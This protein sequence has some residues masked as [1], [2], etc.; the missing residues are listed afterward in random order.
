MDSE[1]AKRQLEEIVHVSRDQCILQKE[2]L[3][4][5]AEEEKRIGESTLKLGSVIS[6]ILYK[7]N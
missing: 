3:A 5:I 6:S 1:F 4:D 2:E 7:T